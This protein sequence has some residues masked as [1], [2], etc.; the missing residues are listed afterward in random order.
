M[1]G[2]TFKRVYSNMKVEHNYEGENLHINIHLSFKPFDI[3]DYKNEFLQS[4]SGSSDNLKWLYCTI[5]NYIPIAI[6]RNTQPGIYA[7]IESGNWKEIYKGEKFWRNTEMRIDTS[8]WDYGSSLDLADNKKKLCINN[9]RELAEKYISPN[10]EW[11]KTLIGQTFSFSSAL[12]GNIV[13][14]H[15]SPDTYNGFTTLAL[16][17]INDSNVFESYNIWKQKSNGSDIC[18]VSIST[19]IT[20]VPNTEN[21]TYAVV[22]A[23]PSTGKILTNFIHIKKDEQE[24]VDKFQYIDGSLSMTGATNEI[25]PSIT[26]INDKRLKLKLAINQTQWKTLS[27]Q[28]RFKVKHIKS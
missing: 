5:Y 23:D 6:I 21:R 25:T 3:R 14:S 22:S 19:T 20:N 28:I 1:A 8:E 4:K 13:F 17:V 27:P 9:L 15:F 12:N 16:N 24:V 2:T 11:Y 26:Q 10:E 7:S 18:K